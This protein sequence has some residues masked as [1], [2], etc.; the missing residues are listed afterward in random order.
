MQHPIAGELHCPDAA[1]G[2]VIVCHGSD[3]SHR[4]PRNPAVAQALRAAGL[5]T[6][7]IDLPNGGQAQQRAALL[8]AIDSAAEDPALASLPLGLF[9]ASSGASYPFEEPEALESV[10]KLSVRWFAQLMCRTDLQS[11][12]KARKL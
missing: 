2:L 6:W 1:G 4:S 8:R 9:G 7:L 10:A 5:A 12:A 3:S 11:A